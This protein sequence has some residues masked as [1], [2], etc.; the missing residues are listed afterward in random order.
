MPRGDDT[1]Q[2][3]PGHISDT[4]TTA[5][6]ARLPNPPLSTEKLV[7][8][9]YTPTPSVATSSHQVSQSKLPAQPAAAATAQ[10][11]AKQNGKTP[12]RPRVS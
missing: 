10:G 12:A 8:R 2:N 11:K 4:S 6:S 5:F 7:P 1:R 3:L 9:R